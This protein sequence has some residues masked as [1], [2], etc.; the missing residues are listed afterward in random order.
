MYVKY[1]SYL[2][3]LRDLK[4]SESKDQV[5][6]STDRALNNISKIMAIFFGLASIILGYNKLFVDINPLINYT[7][8]TTHEPLN[9][10]MLNSD[11]LKSLSSDP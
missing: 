7:S 11:L 4:K 3:F 5:K 10:T 1:G 6:K 8:C 9:Y 2:S